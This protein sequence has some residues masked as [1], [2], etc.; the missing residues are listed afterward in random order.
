MK[1]DDAMK[2]LAFSIKLFIHAVVFL[3]FT[4]SCGNGSTAQLLDNVESYIRERPDSA[5]KVLRSI[6]R[7]KLS[8]RKEKARFSLLHA[9]AIDKN[10]IDTTD[11][12]I[13][14]PA[15]DYYTRCGSPEQRMRAIYYL[16]CIQFNRGD[17]DSAMNSFMTAMEDSAK[18]KDNNLKGLINSSI[19]VFFP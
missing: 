18:V 14:Q 16:G 7:T 11:L 8:G 12:S 10:F 19:A 4:V 3:S 1:Q 17:N 13:I 2:I 9:M 15:V 6:D 5:L